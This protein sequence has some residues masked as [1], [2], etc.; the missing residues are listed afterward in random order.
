M[1]FIGLILGYG[2]GGFGYYVI[3]TRMIRVQ[4]AEKTLETPSAA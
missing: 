1:D 4:E 2:L 3:V